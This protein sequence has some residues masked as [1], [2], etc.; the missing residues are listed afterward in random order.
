M[1][2]PI[3]DTIITNDPNQIADFKQRYGSCIQ[4]TLTRYDGGLLP[5]SELIEDDL[6]DPESIQASPLIVQETLQPGYDIRVNVFGPEIHAASKLVRSIDGR[7]DFGLWSTHELPAA[8]GSKLRVLLDEL[9]LDY[10]CIDLRLTAGGDYFF[11]EVNPSGQFLMVERD[12]GQDLTESLCRLLLGPSTCARPDQVSSA[13]GTMS[14]SG[15]TTR[16]PFGP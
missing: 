3:P 14:A 16:L 5:T 6:Q 4:K 8:F 10:G 15:S 7:Q 13:V 9:G 11:L 2:L 12:T 1:G